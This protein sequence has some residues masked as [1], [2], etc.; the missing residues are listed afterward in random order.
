MYVSLQ[1]LGIQES[2][3]EDEFGSSVS[4]PS[5]AIA[6]IIIDMLQDERAGNDVAA[7]VCRAEHMPVHC[8][9]IRRLQSTQSLIVAFGCIAG[10][11]LSVIR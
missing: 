9:A 3:G 2:R 1:G 7:R 6:H 11:L 4:L 5:W 8:T 10:L